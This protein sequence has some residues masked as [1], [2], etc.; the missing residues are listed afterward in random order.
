MLQ[1]AIDILLSSPQHVFY[2]GRVMDILYDGIPVDCSSDKFHAKAVCSA[3]EGGEV[4]AVRR[5]NDTHYAFSLLS[6]GN[7]TDLGE[8]RVFRGWKNSEDMGRVVAFNDE[9]EMD[10]WSA[11]ECNEYQGTDSTIFPPYMDKKKGIWVSLR[12]SA[13]HDK[14]FQKYSHSANNY[15]TINDTE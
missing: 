8:L 15:E 1:S 2:T 10:V 12:K 13:F 4:K 14:I 7:G 3:F 11:D 5:V 6:Q 9:P